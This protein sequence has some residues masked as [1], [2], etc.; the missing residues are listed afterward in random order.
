M[1][2]KIFR[3]SALLLIISAIAILISAGGC[4]KKSKNTKTGSST[5]INTFAINAPSGLIATAISYTQINLSWQDN[6]NNEDGFEMYRS[7]FSAAGYTL[8]GTVSRG[9]V[10]Y[11]DAGLS[12]TT[13]YYYRVRAFNNIGDYSDYSNVANAFTF[14]YAW[15]P[16]FVM[17][18]GGNFC[19]IALDS[20]SNL[21]SWGNNDYGQLGLSDYNYRIFP[22]RIESDFNWN[23]FA[24]V[25][26]VAA[27][28]VGQFGYT[29][30]LKTDGTLWGWGANA[31]GELGQGDTNLSNAPA[32]EI[33]SASD[34]FAIAAGG[35]HTLAIKTNNTLWAWGFNYYS[36]L[37]LG[38]SE[39][40]TNRITPSQVGTLSDWLTAAAGIMHSM[41]IKT[42]RTLW[43]WGNNGAGQLGLGDV[44]TKTTPIQVTTNTDWSMV[45]AGS[46]FTICLKTDKTFWSWGNNGLGQL[47][48]GDYNS[49]NTPSQ[50]GTLSDWSMVS[51]GNYHAIGLK[52]NGTIWAWGW[53][54]NCQLGLGHPDVIDKANLP[55]Q[56][57]TGSDWSRIAA[58]DRH[59]FGIKTTGA[60]WAWGHNYYGQLGLGDTINRY[61]PCPLGGSAVPSSLNAS[62]I[63]CSQ[64]KL[65]W[66]DN[67]YNETGFIIERK[68]GSTGTWEAIVTINLNSTS[69]LDSGLDIGTSYYYRIMS[70][71]AFGNSIPSAESVAIPI[72][73][74]PINLNMAVISSSQINLAWIDKSPDETGFTI[75][76]SYNGTGSFYQIGTVGANTALYSDNTVTP[77]NLYYY[78]VQAYNDITNSVYSN[79]IS[80]APN[81]PDSLEVFRIRSTM[82]NL[83]W[84]DN[85][86]ET[87]FAIERSYD[88]TGYFNQIATVGENTALYSDNTVTPGNLYYYRVRAYN[89]I[90][91]SD[92][93]E[94]ESA[95]SSLATPAVLTAMAISSTRIDL[96][97]GY[98]I[99]E[100]GE[101]GFKIERKHA[102]G[103]YLQIA[104]VGPD[105]ITYADISVI[106]N[107]YY[108][109]RVKAYAP[110]TESSYSNETNIIIMAQGSWSAF[111][112]GNSHSIALKTDG[113][114][115]SWGSN[116]SGQ[117]GNGT[118]DSRI[119]ADAVGTDSDW[120]M[121]T[122]SD[123]YTLAIKTNRTLW[124][125]GLND[126]YQ[127]GLGN[128]TNR[129]TPSQVGTLSDWSI[130]I[131]ASTQ[132]SG[133]KTN[134]TL[135]SWGCGMLG[136]GVYFGTKTKPFLIGTQ[137]DWSVLAMGGM[138]TI[139]L[140]TNKT[141]WAWGDNTVGQLGDP[142]IEDVTIPNPIGI[143]SDW[144]MIASGTNYGIALKTNNI[145]WA[146]GQN[147]SGQLGLNDSIDRF[148]PSQV[149]INSDWSKISAGDRHTIGIKTNG[150]LWVWGN[151]M[152][153]QLGLGSGIDDRITPTQLTIGSDWFDINAGLNHSF[154]IKSTFNIWAWGQNG[155]GQLGLG[156]TINRNV[157]TL[158]GE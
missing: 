22:T 127:L 69:Y 35:A 1:K 20:N 118:T 56:I 75:E 122:I 108:Y 66:N 107:R 44:I 18:V 14:D 61:V 58:G 19:T 95:I 129:N 2:N 50:A 154:A 8:L 37:G 156:D 112:G 78:R 106:P 158:V 7:R 128:D 36:Q 43:A 85:S 6:S 139:A 64:I 84:V 109:Y 72:L 137:S 88:E 81:T 142:G 138:H 120:S 143:Q 93:S 52:T 131:A 90:T 38:D 151:N 34:W 41:V 146:W 54:I 105:I 114:L 124:A 15:I 26:S 60:I 23:L 148:T 49:R 32:Q 113:T 59:S 94:E 79:N 46:S 76:R 31:N 149:G 3:I 30:A 116:Q 91:N 97:W 152:W 55:M 147:G 132:T 12:Q 67:S 9:V 144:S 150:T 28:Y 47:G 135:W 65:S 98:D 130:V 45:T 126:I 134:G 51:A 70:Y 63:S 140:K 24:G 83:S 86:V 125:W 110:S 87:G 17:I 39:P 80:S 29:I 68:T 136:N 141:L 133:L 102:G 153:Y 145:L 157:P 100:T 40:G 89:D 21:W 62:V 4:P 101:S 33:T 16:S 42:N 119:T 155:S 57:T 103:S 53:N 77:G 96:S 10:S 121:I 117:L 104:T 82:I 99:L 11:S 73:L 74:A 48:L 115:W 111:A 5:S 25:S 92:Y 13:A 123:S 71:N 27:N